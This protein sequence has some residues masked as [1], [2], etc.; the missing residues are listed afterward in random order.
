MP[1]GV[2]SPVDPLI[3]GRQVGRRYIKQSLILGWSGPYSWAALCQVY[4]GS[5][6]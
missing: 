6:S 1:R 3:A 4:A 5:R 2:F